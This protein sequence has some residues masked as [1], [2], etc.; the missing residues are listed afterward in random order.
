[1]WDLNDVITDHI[2]NPRPVR[3][4]AILMCSFNSI[5]FVKPLIAF[6][7][8]LPVH[9]RSIKASDKP[10]FAAQDIKSCLNRADR[11]C[12]CESEKRDTDGESYEDAEAEEMSFHL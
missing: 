12:V 7:N 3:E 6:L 8:R 4:A 11:I 1:M 2:G 9:Q 10:V 5:F